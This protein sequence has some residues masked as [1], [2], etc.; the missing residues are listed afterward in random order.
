MRVRTWLKQI[1]EEQAEVRGGKK[2][3]HFAT[4]FPW[5][6]SHWPQ[7]WNVW[8]SGPVNN[9]SPFSSAKVKQSIEC[10][11]RGHSIH[12]PSAVPPTLSHHQTPKR[13]IAHAPQKLCA[14]T[15]DTHT[16]G[17]AHFHLMSQ[18]S[19]RSLLQVID[20]T[21][22]WSCSAGDMAHDFEASF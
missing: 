17:N 5:T 20:I 14:L 15:D 9:L 8:S 4:S 12:R 10:P 2:S 16:H 13:P 19:H 18:E 7:L 1:Q 22:E 11:P 21:W 3:S 6:V